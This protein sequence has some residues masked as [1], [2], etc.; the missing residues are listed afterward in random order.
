MTVNLVPLLTLATYVALLLLTL[1]VRAFLQWR[2][3]GDTGFR[4][5][6][7]RPGSIE[8]IGGALFAVPALGLLVGFGHAGLW[9][10]TPLWDGALPAWVGA[11]LVLVGGVVTIWSQAAMGASWRVGVDPSESTVLV[12]EGPF[13][14]VRNPVF[15][16]MA[17]GVFG[18]VLIVPTWV[19]LV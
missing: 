10:P 16:G 15:T 5:F 17:V 6:T 3:T 9:N 12:T 19:T 4:G 8:W 2:A 1:G 7:G 14:W 18:L 11:F 13:A